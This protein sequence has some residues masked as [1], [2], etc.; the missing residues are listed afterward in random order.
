MS[1]K[2]HA[3]QAKKSTDRFGVSKPCRGESA[4][5]TIVKFCQQKGEGLPRSL[6]SY[7]G[8]RIEV[9]NERKIRGK[10]LKKKR[11]T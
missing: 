1:V 4:G 11:N 2:K 5:S 6:P 7:N 10:R 3:V 8:V 9:S